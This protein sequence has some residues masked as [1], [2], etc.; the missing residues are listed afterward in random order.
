MS[1]KFIVKNEYI[2][3]TNDTFEHKIKTTTKEDI[4]TFIDSNL[5]RDIK[6]TINQAAGIIVKTFKF[7]HI[8]ARQNT[9]YDEKH[10]YKCKGTKKACLIIELFMSSS[11]NHVVFIN[12]IVRIGEEYD[13]L[14]AFDLF[15]KSMN[16]IQFNQALSKKCEHK[17]MYSMEHIFCRR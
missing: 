8:K 12:M 10:Y 15:N 14:T 3:T 13:T 16:E 2:N 17:I 7:G 4:V 11:V 1:Y 6:H 5:Y 9:F